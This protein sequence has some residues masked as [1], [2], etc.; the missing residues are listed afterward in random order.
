ML[1][2][3][4]LLNVFDL[5][6]NSHD[7]SYRPVWGWHVLVHVCQR[8]RQV[9]FTSP[10]RLN[11]QILCTDRTPV[12]TNLCIWPA[13]PIVVHCNSFRGIS[14]EGNVHA[15]LEHP[16]RVCY[17]KVDVKGPKMAKIVALLQE[18]F[19]VLKRLEILVKAVYPPILTA[20]LLGGSAPSLRHIYLRGVSFP[21][22]PSFLLTTCNLVTLTFHDVPMTGCISPEVV[23]VGLAALTRLKTLNIGFKWP[24]PYRYQRPPPPVT[25]IVL[26]ALTSFLFLGPWDYVEDLVAQIDSPQLDVIRVDYS[27]HLIDASVTQVSKFVDRSLGPKSTLFKHARVSIHSDLISFTLYRH[28]IHPPSDWHS[29]KT[30]I[31]CQGIGGQVS[32]VSQ[33]LCQFSATLAAVVHLELDQVVESRTWEV[34]GGVDWLHLFRQFPAVQMM[35]VSR[36]LASFVAHALEDVTGETAAEL[37]PSLDLISLE[38]EPESS[39][40]E[41][42]FVAARRL[43]DRPVTVVDSRKEFDERVASY[44]SKSENVLSRY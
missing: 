33:V 15:A 20:E 13:F 21:A 23:V 42:K 44:I 41:I 6:R 24:A 5:Y 25:R 11:L 17:V 31:S 18:P 35:H 1:S 26:P 43:S 22:F 27:N 9:I 3:D 30:I 34:L 40:E 4:V 2:D 32:H 12:K 36:Q 16:D 38:E 7:Y 10:R 39:V 19:P 29:A 14:P 28:G 37:L 8:W